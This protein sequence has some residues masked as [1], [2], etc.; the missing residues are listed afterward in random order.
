MPT[1][2]ITAPTKSARFRWPFTRWDIAGAFGDIGILFPIAIALISLN[3]MNPTAVFFT[4]GLAYILAGAYFKIP[5]PVQPFKAVAA[6]ALALQLPPSSIASAGLLMGIL[7]TL[8][9]LTNLVAPLARLFT[10]PVIR[11]IQLGLGLILLREGLRLISHSNVVSIK[12]VSISPWWLAWA[13]GAILL[14]LLRSRRFPA[15]LALLIAGVAF[16]LWAGGHALLP[17]SWGPAPFQLLHPHA[18][19]L[20]KVLVALVLPQFALTF[21][22]S[23]VA[24]ENTAQLL[25]GAQARR[26]TT[27]ALSVSIGL[28]NLVSGTLLSA[29]TCHGS[30][31]VTAHYKFGARTEK[32]GYVIGTVCLLL[33]LFGQSAITLLHLI[34]TAV[35][36]VFLVY[37][38]VQHGMFIRDLMSRK[39]FLL[40]A[41]GVGIISLATTNLTYGFLAGFLLH[42]LLMLHERRNALRQNVVPSHLDS[43]R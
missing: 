37:V 29:P 15:A 5:M 30:G 14:A 36:G 24:T 13:G 22:N 28:M 3:H 40:I 43:S 18:D 6:I 35:L 42:G 17:L 23:I 34:P 39:A 1:T 21:G 16:G 12:G 4:A 33:A 27:R 32:S 31:G 38:G 8:I 2:E 41:V 7:L 19:E 26:V 11:G 20:K 9:G 25:Y 10:L